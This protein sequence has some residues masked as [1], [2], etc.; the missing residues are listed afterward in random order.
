M[1]PMNFPKSLLVVLLLFLTSMIRSQNNYEIQVYGSELIPKGQNIIE[2]HSN[3]TVIGPA[4]QG[5]D[6]VA[7]TNH[8]LRETVEITRG[9]TS[10]MEIAVYTFTTLTP[11]GGYNWVGN[12]IRPRISIPEGW[13]WPIG[14][15][16]SNELGYQ[17]MSYA[18]DQWS[19]E[20]RYIIDKKIN[21]L[22]LSFN[23]T[24]DLGLQGRTDKQGFIFT[25]CFKISY[26]W[27]KKFIPGIEYFSTL[28]PTMAWLGLSNQQH[29]LCLSVDL[30][31]SPKWEI[32][33]GLCFGLTSTTDQF[34]PKI[35]VGRKF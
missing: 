27:T 1:P 13:H 17:R 15:S 7:S 2:L 4:T 30:D 26:E 10:W 11:D 22:Y 20:M 28:G 35:V 14:L 9:I 31:L 5:N 21:K 32:N 3:F 33:T 23:P 6:G 18:D 16:L 24:F 19:W 34:I 8:Q 29:Q 12:H 25:P